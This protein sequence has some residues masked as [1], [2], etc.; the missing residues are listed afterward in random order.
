LAAWGAWLA[1]VPTLLQLPVGLWVL[2]QLPLAER[3]ALLGSDLYATGLFALAL[4]AALRLMHQLAAVALGDTE[5]KQIVGSLSTM[6]LVVALMVAA[7]T[8][9]Q[10]PADAKAFAAPPAVESSAETSIP[11]PAIAA[12]PHAAESFAAESFAATAD[13]SHPSTAQ[14]GQEFSAR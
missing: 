3:D 8:R 7:W 12:E 2:L 11:A 14:S 6:A 13:R 4:L 10:A 1:L 9:S 5:R